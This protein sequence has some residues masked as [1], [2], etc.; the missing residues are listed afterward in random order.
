MDRLT[1]AQKLWLPLLLSLACL[2]AMTGFDAWSLHQVRIEEREND[3]ANN[4]DNVVSLV[5]HYPDLVLHGV[6]TRDAAQKEAIERIKA[7]RFGKDGYYTVMTDEPR[8]LRHPFKPELVGRALGDFKDANG[9]LLYRDAVNIAK[10]AG[11]GF[12]R[13]VW[14]RPGEDRPIPKL[15]RVATFKPWGWTF[16][17]G[18]YIDDIDTAFY[19]SLIE[20]GSVLTAVAVA[21]SVLVI[22]INRG[23][24][25]SLGGEPASAAEAARRIASGDLSVPV[26]T[27]G[28]SS[29]SLL[30]TVEA[31][32]AQLARTVGA[33][34]G[35]TESIA[36]ATK[37][38][39]AGNSDLSQR[40][41]ERAASLQETASSMEQMTSMVTNNADNALH[42]N[43]MA[44]TASDIA[45]RGGELVE[46]V[47]GTMQEISNSSAR[48]AEIVSVIEGIAFQ[49]NILALNAAVEAAR[50]G[51]QG[52]GFAVV[53]SEVRSLALRAAAAAKDVKA[54]I[55]ESVNRVESGSALVAES[56]TAIREI[57]GAVKR[58]DAIVHEIAAA[59]NEQSAGIQQVG[60]AI[61][62]MDSI[63]QQNA[64]L[65]EQAAAAAH[66][67]SGQAS[68]LADIVEAFRLEAADRGESNAD[69][70]RGA[71][72]RVHVAFA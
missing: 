40:T 3:L 33:I 24:Q 68:G 67:L 48:I 47:I 19:R 4:A 18:V 6:L 8:M 21:L 34:G 38:I 1:F 23:L 2:T 10:A 16:L 14:P 49:T 52:R 71:M 66:S 26:N 7:M 37:E 35:S 32:R 69:H 9:T 62:Q 51:E 15:T 31:M 22:V 59:S 41:E 27:S 29:D 13:Y 39:A 53:A 44:S 70:R 63:I 46:R 11:A 54:L 17:N 25:R 5:R 65:V 50:A 61:S 12:I 64:A 43:E 20:S 60:K 72:E 36:S 45:G 56:G 30:S 55:G 58:V 28:A 57:V 42:A